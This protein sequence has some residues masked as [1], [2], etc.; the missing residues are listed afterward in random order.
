MSIDNAR[1]VEVDSHV[2]IDSTPYSAQLN[3]V[4]NICGKFRRPIAKSP[5]RTMHRPEALFYS[6]KYKMQYITKISVVNL[7]CSDISRNGR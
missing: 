1:E 6:F 5:G 4:P 2:W 7:R 3:N